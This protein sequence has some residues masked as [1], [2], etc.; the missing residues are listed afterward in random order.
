M[1]IKHRLFGIFQKLSNY[2]LI[3]SM[4]VKLRDISTIYMLKEFYSYAGI[5]GMLA[6]SLI[7]PHVFCGLGVA[8]TQVYFSLHRILLPYIINTFPNIN[9]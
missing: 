5:N 9:I 6:I 2:G 3:C 7:L 8:M 4:D 1:C